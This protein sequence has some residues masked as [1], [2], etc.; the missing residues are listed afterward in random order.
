MILGMTPLV[1]L[2]VV[3][4]LVGIG[5]GLAV[6]WGMLGSKRM[7]G[8]AVVFLW[9]TVLTSAS[10]FILPATQFLPSHATGIL[11][12]IILAFTLYAW[13][14]KRLAGRWRGVYAGTAVA[15]LYLNVFVLVVQLF[16]KVPSLKALAPQQSEPPFT[17]TQGIVLL[18]FIAWGVLAVKRFHPERAGAARAGGMV[19]DEDL[20]PQ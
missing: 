3:I 18:V 5:T 2:H 11:S 7:P 1:F 13:Y 16:L 12:L 20:A 4:S 8:L 6:A 15:A 9:T 10:G 19:D 17:V 14:G